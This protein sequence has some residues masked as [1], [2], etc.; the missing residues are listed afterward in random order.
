M[1]SSPLSCT[2]RGTRALAIAALAT[3]PFALIACADDGSSGGTTS[4]ETQTDTTVSETI[5]L[6]GGWAK[7]VR[8]YVLERRS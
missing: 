8:K 5:T 6:E 3:L 4:P 1:H 2:R 7:A